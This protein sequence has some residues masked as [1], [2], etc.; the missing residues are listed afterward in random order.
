MHYVIRC[1]FEKLMLF[2]GL[3]SVLAFVV[4]LDVSTRVKE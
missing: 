1:I 3:I 2:V 4:S